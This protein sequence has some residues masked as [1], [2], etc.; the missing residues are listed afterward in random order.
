M[1]KPHQ[2]K[3]SHTQPSPSTPPIE[4]TVPLP[5]TPPQEPMTNP[6][7]DQPPMQ[8]PAPAFV[9]PPSQVLG[10]V[11][12]I[13]GIVAFLSGLTVIGGIGLGIGAVVVGVIA[14]VKKQGK[15]MA[16]AGVALGGFAMVF[17]VGLMVFYIF[18]Y[19]Q[20][21]KNESYS[22][23]SSVSKT[24]I[25]NTYPKGSVAVF[26]H[27]NVTVTNIARTPVTT[28]LYTEQ[29]AAHMRLSMKSDG[30]A[31][32]TPDQL[33]TGMTCVTAESSD[34]L[35]VDSV[36][37]GSLTIVPPTTQS[38]VIDVEC[39]VAVGTS[40]LSIDYSDYGDYS[41]NYQKIT[42]SLKLE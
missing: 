16:I 37:S 3:R 19:A 5:P 17:S 2:H 12:L 8:P 7:I 34:Y 31:T 42:S 28:T 24:A 33:V 38:V 23:S 4:T 32:L 40:D 26:G 29:Q 36:V 30:D 15:G 27:Y 25:G 20:V 13:L 41:T 39:P 6:V 18:L 14:L 11:A 35:T 22:S 21:G 1:D 9:A 10:I